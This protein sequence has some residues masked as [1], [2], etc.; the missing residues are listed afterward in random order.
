MPRRDEAYMESRKLQIIEA[1]WRCFGQRGVSATT[2]R[3]IA[4]EA[5]LSTGAVYVHFS[6]KEAIVDAAFE[7][8]NQRIARVGEGLASGEDPVQ[9]IDDLIPAFFAP[10]DRPEAAP[11]L[12]GTVALLAETVASEPL[13]ARYCEQLH[14]MIEGMSVPLGEMAEQGL[15][16][17]DL[18]PRMV[19]RFLLAI[20]EGYRIH[21]VVDPDF[22]GPDFVQTM[23]ALL[24]QPQG[25]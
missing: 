1:A 8:S 12:R 6:G 15:L 5:G 19:A 16:P 2:M 22:S 21:R 13:R 14:A 3:Q 4:A 10:M 24:F 11:M 9:A 25:R 20:H 23:A 18:D 7:H 17:A